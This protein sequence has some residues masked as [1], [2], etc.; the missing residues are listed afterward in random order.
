MQ[1]QDS[2]VDLSSQ[3]P[4]LT[5]PSIVNNDS[6]VPNAD[7]LVQSIPEVTASQNV[8]FST[9]SPGWYPSFIWRHFKNVN[10]CGVIS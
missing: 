5:S 10:V 4:I 1:F 9:L 6:A 8:S 2:A 3:T 7:S